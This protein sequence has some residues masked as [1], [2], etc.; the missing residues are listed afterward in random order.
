MGNK[1]KTV[2]D[3]P[4]YLIESEIAVRKQKLAETDYQAIKFAEGSLSADEYAEI[5]AKRE[6]WRQEINTLEMELTA[7]P[8]DEANA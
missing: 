7:F 8:A 1:I 3:K 2:S 6:T 4:K 5:K